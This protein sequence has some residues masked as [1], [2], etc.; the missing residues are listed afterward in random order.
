MLYQYDHK[1]KW[2]KAAIKALKYLANHRKNSIIVP[3]DHWALIATEKL[4]VLEVLSVKEKE[5]LLSH[6]LKICD[7]IRSEQITDISHHLFGSFNLEGRIT[8][9]STRLEGLIA[10]FNTLPEDA[11]DQRDKLFSS[12]RLGIHFLLN[13]Q[14]SNGKYA[15]AFTRSVYQSE[16]AKKDG[17]DT[18]IRIDYIQHAISALLGYYRLI[19]GR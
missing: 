18:E 16:D 1:K 13:A 2:L 8:P 5:L 19:D 15:G 17:R 14:L 9:T 6:S 12:I 3:A 7:V 11:I 10:A 4:F